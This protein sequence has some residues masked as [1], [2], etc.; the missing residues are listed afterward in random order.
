MK[1][2]RSDLAVLA[3][4]TIFISLPFAITANTP[5]LHDSYAHVAE[6]ASETV[7]DVLLL[8]L[9][10]VRDD[11]FFGRW[12]ISHIGW[13]SNGLVTTPSVGIFGT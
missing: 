4:L 1:L 7:H 13:T 2:G 10:P 9:H 11:L 3:A 12:D 5:L 8:F 6:A